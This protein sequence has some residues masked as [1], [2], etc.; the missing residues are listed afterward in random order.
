MRLET[1]DYAHATFF[2]ALLTPT[3]WVLAQLEDLSTQISS[4]LC[5]HIRVT[6]LVFSASTDGSNFLS[7]LWNRQTDRF[8]EFHGIQVLPGR[9]V[10]AH[11]VIVIKT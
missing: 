10:D 1:F 2:S 6:E 5:T 7:G 11:E 3:G 4:S 9:D 8:S